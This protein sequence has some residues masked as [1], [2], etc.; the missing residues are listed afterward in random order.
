MNNEA[1][2]VRCAA[3][4]AS[5]HK[6]VTDS[7]RAKRDP[8]ASERGPAPG[9]NNDSPLQTHRRE[10]HEIHEGIWHALGKLQEVT[11]CLT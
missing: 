9:S 3:G 5:K 4:F 7:T 10:N 6:I 11:D 2:T 8:E 1:P